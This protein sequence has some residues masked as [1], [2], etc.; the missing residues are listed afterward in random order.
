MEAVSEN[1]IQTVM[2]HCDKTLGQIREEL[3]QIKSQIDR[4]ARLENRV[5]ALN[6][7][8][9]QTRSQLVEQINSLGQRYGER[10]AN[11]EKVERDFEQRQEAIETRLAI[12]EDPENQP[13]YATKSELEEI[14]QRTRAMFDGRLQEIEQQLGQVFNNISEL[15][16]SGG[17]RQRHVD[18]PASDM[19]SQ[20]VG[21]K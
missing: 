15:T 16:L 13:N 12:L 11:V 17:H 19:L 18:H 1:A 20:L 4:I 2:D 5:A 10:L 6:A 3:N 14:V 21:Q 8:A 9:E 7:A